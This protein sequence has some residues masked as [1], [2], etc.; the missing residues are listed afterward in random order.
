MNE[1]K[2]VLVHGGAKMKKGLLVAVVALLLVLG[3]SACGADKI[4]TCSVDQGWFKKDLKI[5]IGDFHPNDDAFVCMKD[6][7]E[8]VEVEVEVEVTREVE[9]EVEVTKIVEVEVTREVEKEVEFPNCGPWTVNA[10]TRNM[11]WAAASDGSVD[12]CQAEADL[13]SVRNGYTTH[14][15]LRVPFELEICV[16]TLFRDGE[17]VHQYIDCDFGVEYEAGTYSIEMPAGY[18]K[19]GGF[20]A[21]PL[22]GYGWRADQ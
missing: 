8:P 5:K 1:K 3:L 6:G 12:V 22:V 9:K 19:N 2:F 18:S 21:R 13:E 20:R 17:V 15:T 14:F 16:G 7:F 11:T 4:P 10:E